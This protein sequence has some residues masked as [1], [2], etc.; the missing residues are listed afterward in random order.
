MR[1]SP[2]IQRDTATAPPA[3]ATEPPSDRPADQRH[4]PCGQCGAQ[5]S[6]KPGADALECPYCGHVNPIARA[7]GAIDELDFSEAL[8]RMEGAEVHEERSA[9]R[10]GGCGAEIDPPPGLTSF[11]CPF[12]GDNIVATA[13]SRRLIKPKSVLPFHIVRDDARARFGKWLRTRWFAPNDLKRRANAQ[14]R[15]Q[16]VYVPYWT[17]DCDTTS[18]YTGLRGKHYWVT[19]GSGKNRRRA[20]RTRWRP[21]AGTVR[22]RF[23]DLLVL[24]SR[25]LPGKHAQ[26]LEPWD[27]NNLTPY[28]DDYLSGFRAESYQIDLVEGFGVAQQIMDAAIRQQVRRDIG[29]DEQQIHSL[30]TRHANITFKHI[31]LPV[32][33]SAYRYRGK[34]Y[35]FVVNARSGE[36]QGE[37]PYSWIKITLTVLTALSAVGAAAWLIAQHT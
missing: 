8:R 9:V 16:G 22:L 12:C 31:L 7:A 36:V 19:V 24:A 13:V 32:W 21:A 27:L 25:S 33:L 28:Q 5:L 2:N 4:F 26:A 34:V 35:R 14:D 29:G 11:A 17:Y 10:C 20:R 15:L 30:S 3:P 6:F 18:Q 1:E 23:D 37:R